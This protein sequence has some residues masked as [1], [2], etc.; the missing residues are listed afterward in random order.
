MVTRSR[1]GQPGS[2]EFRNS[3]R[4]RQHGERDE[5]TRLEIRSTRCDLA[6]NDHVLLGDLSRTSHIVIDY[7]KSPIDGSFLTSTRFW[8]PSIKSSSFFPNNVETEARAGYKRR[9]SRATRPIRRFPQCPEPRFL[10]TQ[11]KWSLSDP[12]RSE[13]PMA[14]GVCVPSQATT[15]ARSRRPSTAGYPD[16]RREP[17]SPMRWQR[18]TNTPA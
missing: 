13:C 9:F 7:G 6:K 1:Y 8:R 18:E 12:R 4:S 16:S 17:R 14:C 3:F 5:L 10:I 15:V 2:Q 11:K